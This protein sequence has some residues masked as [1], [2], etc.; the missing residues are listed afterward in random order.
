MVGVA[1]VSII[2]TAIDAWSVNG[3]NLNSPDIA[4][5]F[6]AISLVPYLTMLYYLTK[7][8]T[9]TPQVSLFGF[10]FL[11]V[12]V[13]ATIPAGIYAKYQYHDILA[14]IDWLHGLAESLLT[15][16]NLLIITGFRQTLRGN[17]SGN[18]TPSS[19]FPPS[20]ATTGNDLAEYHAKS[21]TSL[22]DLGAIVLLVSL[23]S[24]SLSGFFPA[25]HIEPVNALSLPT[26]MVHTSSI[27]EWLIAM[28]LI[29]EHSFTANNPRWK[30]M[31]IAMIPSHVSPPLLLNP[32]WI[33]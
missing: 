33:L 19:Y 26:W 13:F 2:S 4:S 14:N 25:P 24:V 1:D 16:T 30:G 3:A 8:E 21:S 32:L 29:W 12:F 22:N 15:V 17:Q 7:K 27:L 6:F 28:K 10:Y 5:A 18:K 23:V 31:T 20:S 11:L 9:K